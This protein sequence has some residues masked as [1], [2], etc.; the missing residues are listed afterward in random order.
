MVSFSLRSALYD[1]VP[2]CSRLPKAFMDDSLFCY[3]LDCCKR[4]RQLPLFLLLFRVEFVRHHDFA[5]KWA[6]L[7]AMTMKKAA[8]DDDLPNFITFRKGPHLPPEVLHAL[9]IL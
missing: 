6:E 8:Y 7:G 4:Y 9:R 5:H 3:T 2:V 1:T